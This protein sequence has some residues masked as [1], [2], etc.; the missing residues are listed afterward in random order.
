VTMYVMIVATLNLVLG[1]WLGICVHEDALDEANASAMP[2]QPITNIIAPA[3]ALTGATAAS[4]LAPSQPSAPNAPVF[5]PAAVDAAP[6]A[7]LA[8]QQPIDGQALV[9]DLAAGLNV[10]RGQMA[11]LDSRLRVSA[12]APEVAQAAQFLAE[13]K[14]SSENYLAQQEQAAAALNQLNPDESTQGLPHSELQHALEAQR[15]DIEAAHQN[16]DAIDFDA[17]L[18]AGFQQ[19]LNETAKV[20]ESNYVL[21]DK[22]SGA[23]QRLVT[24]AEADEA[25]D[26]IT[27]KLMVGR[28]QFET[29]LETWWRDHKEAGRSLTLALIE[30][31][32][33]AEM[34]LTHGITVGDGVLHAISRMISRSLRTDDLATRYSG[35]K[36]LVMLPDTTVQDSTNTVERLRQSIAASDFLRGEQPIAVTVSCA[37]AE[38]EGQDTLFTLLDR[39]ELTLQ[40][41]KRYG[42]N[43]TYIYEENHPSPVT[44]P[45]LDVTARTLVL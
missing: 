8:A 5:E 21:G 36:F 32:R 6:L 23:G 34:N 42:S 15:Q 26:A 43:C 30:I 2:F 18:A 3:S 14:T 17:D 38:A 24:T 22:L 12:D 11:D 39:V 10:Y 41:S 45:S 33:F 4:Q 9:A 25:D 16:V 20:I 44:P 31:D 1:Y 29:A 40:E 28:D 13:F 7:P 35:G 37:V 27:R 19:L